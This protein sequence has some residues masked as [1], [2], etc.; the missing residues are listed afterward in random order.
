MTQSRS[1]PPSRD[2]HTSHIESASTGKL[3]T[4]AKP[5]EVKE[6]KETKVRAGTIT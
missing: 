3:G 1:V 6:A 5:K 4:K 2:Q